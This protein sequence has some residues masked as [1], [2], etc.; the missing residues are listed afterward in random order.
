MHPVTWVLILGSSLIVAFVA[1]GLIV[2]QVRKKSLAAMKAQASAPGFTVAELEAMRSAGRISDEE[3]RSLRLIALGMAPAGSK[4]P[5]S[6][7]SPPS[8]DVDGN[9]HT[10]QG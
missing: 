8:Q 6:P 10:A 9:E 2:M 5:A 3:F 4:K 1:L 7:L